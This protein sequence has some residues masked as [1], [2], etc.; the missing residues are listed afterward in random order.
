[1]LIMFMQELLKDVVTIENMDDNIDV[2]AT[3]NDNLYAIKVNIKIFDNVNEN[4]KDIFDP[5]IWDFL[6]SKI[7]DLLAMKVPKR[8]LSIMKGP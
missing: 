8:D 5:R 6:Q 7:I 4:E 1:M 3:K 2:N